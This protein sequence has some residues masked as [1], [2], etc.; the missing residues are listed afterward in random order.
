MLY[1]FLFFILVAFILL[2]IRAFTVESVMVMLTLGSL[3]WVLA[4]ASWFLVLFSYLALSLAATAYSVRKR[5]AKGFSR[6]IDNVL[7]NGLV[8]FM[9]AVFASTGDPAFLLI[10]LGSVS[11][12]LADTLSSE[13]GLLSR[14]P[15]FMITSFRRA[16][17]GVNG[18]VTLLGLSAGLAGALVIAGLASVIP[19]QGYESRLILFAAVA[20]SGFIGTLVDSLLGA[21]FENRNLM[22][23]GSV[24][25]ITTLAGGVLTMIIIGLA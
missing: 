14:S 18:G 19:W 20:A 10:F 9:A 11:A 24:N 16:V 2:N 21:V 23:N 1:V 7:S 8:P 5:G 4:G 3:V 25:F 15:P 17:P 12:A 6:G 22:T 13:I